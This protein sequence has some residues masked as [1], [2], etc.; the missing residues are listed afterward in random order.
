MI[1]DDLLLKKTHVNR[2]MSEEDTATSIVSIQLKTISNFHVKQSER[3]RIH[4][5]GSPKTFKNL[6]Y[7]FKDYVDMTNEEFRKLCKNNLQKEHGFVII[8][9][10][11]KKYISKYRYEIIQ[12]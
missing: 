11:R 10:C 8:D 3:M 1:F 9:V 5:S 6:N 12:R 7:I 4:L 2:I